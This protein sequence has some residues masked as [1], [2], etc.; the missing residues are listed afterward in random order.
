MTPHMNDGILTDHSFPILGIDSA[1]A[2]APAPVPTLALDADE[3][4]YI[5]LDEEDAQ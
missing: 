4:I 1:P 5:E 2:P 3:E